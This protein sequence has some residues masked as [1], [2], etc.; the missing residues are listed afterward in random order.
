[1]FVHSS[2]PATR[3]EGFTHCGSFVPTELRTYK[4]LEFWVRWRLNR[5]VFEQPGLLLLQPFQRVAEQLPKI[6]QFVALELLGWLR[7]EWGRA[8]PGALK[9]WQDR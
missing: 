3:E 8:A 9:A 7:F 4:L 2:A 5:I 6:C 1:M